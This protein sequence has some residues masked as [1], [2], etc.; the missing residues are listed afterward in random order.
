MTTL[1][2]KEQ[3]KGKIMEAE[4]VIKSID[5]SL[6]E[7]PF[8]LRHSFADGM[9]VREI[10]C[11]KG[12][13]IVTKIFKQSHATFLLS[14]ECSIATADGV[15]RIKAPFVIM[16]HAGTKRVVFCHTD[17]WWATVHSNPD[18]TK[19]LTKIEG[20]VIAETFDDVPLSET[21]QK[22]IDLAREVVA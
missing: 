22:I 7:N 5:G 20:R 11:P 3:F 1:I 8:P 17:V 9:Y 19:S 13:L 14:G 6:G 2:K 15:Q 4:R 18:D 12:A 21:E 16:T 10:F